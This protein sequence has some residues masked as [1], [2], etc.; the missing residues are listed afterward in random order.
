M[1]VEEL[2]IR[3]EL[4]LDVEKGLEEEIKD[5][6]YRLA[7]RLHRLY[8]HQKDSASKQ[9]C[10]GRNERGNTRGK[11]LSEVNINIK[12]EGGTTIQIKEIKKE[13]GRN[14]RCTR[15]PT[16]KH[17]RKQESIAFQSPRGVR[18]DWAQSLRTASSPSH[19]NRKIEEKHRHKVK[20]NE[21]SGNLGPRRGKEDMGIKTALLQLGWKY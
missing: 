6:I 11:M 4:E 12:M 20:E 5:G 15:I 7:L 1:S 13:A 8:Q 9:K 18:F 10:D 3:E 14:D 17:A 2:K 21:G 16:P 19:I